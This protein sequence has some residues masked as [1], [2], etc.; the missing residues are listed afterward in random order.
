[1]FLSRPHNLAPID[2]NI[3]KWVNNP[4]QAK[5]FNSFLNNNHLHH[6]RHI[7][8][9][10]IYDITTSA[11]KSCY[12]NFKME[13]LNFS[14]LTGDILKRNYPKL[15]PDIEITC[16]KCNVEH[17]TNPHL[18][19][20]SNHLSALYTIL[21]THRIK[22]IDLLTKVN[23]KSVPSE[24][25]RTVNK[26][27]FFKHTLS[28][29]PELLV[30]QLTHPSLLI[31]NFI[32]YELSYLFISFISQKLVVTNFFRLYLW[33]FSRFIQN[34][35][36][37]QSTETL[38][39]WTTTQYHAEEKEKLPPHFQIEW[40]NYVNKPKTALA[41]LGH[42]SQNL[43]ISPRPYHQLSL[44]WSLYIRWTSSNFLHSG[45]WQ[46]HQNFDL[47]DIT[48]ILDGFLLKN[49]YILHLFFLLC[50]HHL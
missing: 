16:P 45:T 17:D 46:T 27:E 36:A 5:T 14:L 34:H 33:T 24:V 6:L 35:M 11:K 10:H 31:H 1:M 21:C 2:Q 40:S 12:L 4:I 13:S 23:D 30:L 28:Q 19:L 38:H 47:Y 20:C 43:P 42:L 15:Y 37:R 26:T 49:F 22:L 32:P 8:K 18:S 7:I 41:I 3:W 29:T 25:M 44:M 48:D 9:E 39:F 50:I